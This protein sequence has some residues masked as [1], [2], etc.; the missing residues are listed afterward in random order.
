MLAGVTLV[1]AAAWTV[2]GLRNPRP[3]RTNLR[4]RPVFAA[5]AAGAVLIVT[6]VFEDTSAAP[7]WLWTVIAGACAAWLVGTL[8]ASAFARL[9]AAGR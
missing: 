1:L 8:A 4:R 6:L 3:L 5:V 7:S 9:D 2:A